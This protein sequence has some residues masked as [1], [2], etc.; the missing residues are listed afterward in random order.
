MNSEHALLFDSIEVSCS[1]EVVC[2]TTGE[3]E[4]YFATSRSGKV[5]F[6]KKEAVVVLREFLKYRTREKEVAHIIN[7]TVEVVI[8]RH[9]FNYPS[10]LHEDFYSAVYMKVFKVLPSYDFKR[11]IFTFIYTVARNE[12]HNWIYHN[13]EKTKNN[14]SLDSMF[15]GVTEEEE[16][17]HD[18]S[19]GRN[20]QL[21]QFMLNCFPADKWIIGEEIMDYLTTLYELEGMVGEDSPSLFKEPEEINAF[22]IFA[23]FHTHSDVFLLL[24]AY[25][26]VFGGH[27]DFGALLTAVSFMRS[28]LLNA[29]QIKK[30]ISDYVLFKSHVTELRQGKIP[31]ELVPLSNRMVEEYENYTL[32]K[33]LDCVEG[34]EIVDQRLFS[35]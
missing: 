18:S 33:I 15:N 22:T 17:T 30:V 24:Y 12:I 13:L 5:A 25:Y 31:H 4:V 1:D 11:D 16:L 28:K 21:Y 35:R 26:Q 27:Q 14:V 3:D 9:Y 29:K 19:S 20:G 23:S 34:H 6:N 2:S 8:N 32:L 10:S 7:K